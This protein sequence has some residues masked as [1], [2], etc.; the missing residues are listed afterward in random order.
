MK[1]LWSDENGSTIPKSFN[2]AFTVS[3][4]G[5]ALVR[6]ESLIADTPLLRHS[7]G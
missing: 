1:R 6:T 4:P 2:K 3:G 5:L 7:A